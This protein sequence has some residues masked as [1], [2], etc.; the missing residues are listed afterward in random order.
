MAMIHVVI[1]VYNAE[2]FLQEA[3]DS[4]L[5]QSFKGIDIVL[6]NDGSTDGSMALCDTI[7]AKE[8]R[9]SVIH[10]KNGGVSVA[11][12]TGIEYF[13]ERCS[14]EDYIAFLDAD[15]VWC[16]NAFPDFPITHGA[17]LIGYSVYCANAE[18]NRLRADTIHEDELLITQYGETRWYAVGPFTAYLYASHLLRRYR[19]CFPVGVKGN[20]DVIFHQQVGFCSKKIQYLHTPLYIY[21]MNPYSY[22]HT[23]KHTKDN[24][25]HVARAWHSAAGWS[26]DLPGID[27]ESDKAWNRF[28]CAMAGARMLEAA[29]NLAM[30]GA[31]Y[32]TMHSFLE[33]GPDSHLFSYI[34]MDSLAAWQRSHLS[35]YRK[36]PKAFYVK[37][38]LRG[39]LQRCLKRLLSVRW[40]RSLREAKDFPLKSIDV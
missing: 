35:L 28:C 22:T 31:S 2:R 33:S 20:E 32:S 21:R 40:I 4:V 16:A 18:A 30:A 8:E 12:N 3:V 14:D 26:K 39:T 24:A 38:R 36:D 9:V 23:V 5:N 19:L 13:L 7:A 25:A 10:Q 1:P 15:D 37:F 11:R 27:E 29:Y 34:S 6:V 17:D